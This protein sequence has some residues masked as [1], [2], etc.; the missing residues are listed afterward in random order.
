MCRFLCTYYCRCIFR[1][2]ALNHGSATF[3]KW[4][5]HYNVLFY[6]CA[7]R[8]WAQWGTLVIPATWEA[9]AGGF[10]GSGLWCNINGAKPLGHL[11]ALG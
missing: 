3:Q 8:N 4:G 7:R 2:Y 6:F 11:S 5:F 9:E 1:S 10:R